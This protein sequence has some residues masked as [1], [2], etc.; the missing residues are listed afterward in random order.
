[1]NSSQQDITDRGMDM[2]LGSATREFFEETLIK[3]SAES[4]RLTVSFRRFFERYERRFTHACYQPYKWLVL[5][6][7]L[8]ISTLVLGVLAMVVS[9]LVS[10]AAG[11]Y[12]AVMWARL[13]SFFTPMTV[14]VIGAE[15]M[16]PG[17]SYVVVANHQSLYDIYALYG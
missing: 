1:M 7:F 6:P 16:E 12:F 4:K 11:R 17:K 13:N 9:L 5:A 15:N 10:P 14:S 8:V 3:Y 2:G